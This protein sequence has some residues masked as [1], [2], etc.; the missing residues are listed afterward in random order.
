VI[1]G[2]PSFPEDYLARGNDRRPNMK[3]TMMVAALALLM[4]S[5]AAMAQTVRE[6]GHALLITSRAYFAGS[7]NRCPQFRVID[8]AVH[9]EL[10]AVGVGKTAADRINLMR[11][12]GIHAWAS[13][14]DEDPSRFCKYVWEEFGPNNG[15]ERQMLEAK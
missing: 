9:A 7:Q 15:S 2:E 12:L 6:Q 13:A 8:E 10:A 4:T 5:G 1:V 3:R 11:H 14:Y